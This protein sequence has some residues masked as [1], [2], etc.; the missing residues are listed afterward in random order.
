[1]INL[2][3]HL[4]DELNITYWQLRQENTEDTSVFHINRE[5]KELLRNILLAKGIQLL[6]ESLT[7]EEH[8]KVT[9][10]IGKYCLVFMDANHKD[11]KTHI[12]LAKLADMQ[13]DQQLKKL[14]WFKLKNLNL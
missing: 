3:K 8:G 4:C 6:D 13:N 9:V 7:I 14:T 1:M 5:E 12:N 2:D 11:T 10:T